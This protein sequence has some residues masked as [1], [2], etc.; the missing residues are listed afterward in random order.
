MEVIKMAEIKM[1]LLEVDLTKGT[2]RVID[3]TEDVK[4]YLGARGLANKLIWDLVPQGAD[5]L[6]PD[7]ILHVGVGPLTGLVGTKTFL[8]FKSPLT[9]W[10]GRSGISSYFGEEI[11]KA[12][13]NAGILVKGKAKKPVYLYVHDEKVEIRDASDL[14][15]KWK[16]ETEVTLRDRLNEQ[17]GEMFGVLCIGPAGENLVRC[18]NASAEFVHSASKWGCGAV[19]GSK[20]LKAIAVRGTKGP[21][22]ADHGR[23]WELFR[24]YAGSPKTALH[25]LGESRWGHTKTPCYLYRYA[26]EGIK[27]N[28]LGYDK[29]AEKS[30]YYEHQLKYHVWT[31]G[32]PGC[33]AACFVPFFKHNQKGAFG[34]DFR[35]DD[36]GGFTANIMLGYEEMAEINALVDELGMDS[37][38]LGGLVAWA[39]DL[40]EHG[41]ISKED[42]GGID[43]Q[44]G[45]LEATCELIKKIA[46]KEGRAPAAIA[47]GFRR[48]YEVFGEKSRWY[49][50]EVHGCAAPT[51][52]VRNKHSGFGL[53]YATSH[54]GARMGSGIGSGLDEAATACVFAFI[55]FI[56]IWGSP[57][58]AVRQFLNAACGW[59][60]SIE[61]VKD[62][63]VRNYYF[64]RC[65]SLREGY[66]PSK[67]DYLPPRAFDEPITDK[68][69]TTWVWSKTEFEEAKRR[70]YVES[71]KL[72]E[73]GLP[74]R[75]ELERLG[76][77]FVIPILEPMGGVG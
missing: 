73:E 51:Y 3:V 65:V 1:S 10:A 69:G 26:A 41:I 40:Y 28:H 11:I 43:L 47:E 52:D 37:E 64:N 42:L 20:N 36:L 63:E 71:L 72:T 39:M 38:E 46:C 18:A 24:N 8:S 59:N 49:G 68:Y 56:Q 75:K 57:E 50:F 27:N 17:T 31:D 23:V 16:Q 33:A 13:Y 2:T 53:P 4:K 76:L 25:K 7:N 54:N 34:G 62:I 66:H 15:G 19:M 22:Y 44:W 30:N 6:G 14:W 55:P 45:S 74:P 29:I 21:L 48:A 61:N 60:L 32:C 58:E 77:D 9:G 67:D 12:R 35:H 5:A 70:Y